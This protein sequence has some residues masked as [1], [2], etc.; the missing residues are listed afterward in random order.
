MHKNAGLV[1]KHDNCL[2]NGAPGDLRR[3]VLQLVGPDLPGASHAE[4]AR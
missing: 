4:D 2:L 3:L 1:Y